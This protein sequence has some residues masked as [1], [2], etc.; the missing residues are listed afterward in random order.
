MIYIY[1]MQNYYEIIGVSVNSDETTIK[2]AYL[3]KIKFY[4]PDVYEG[5]KL[6]AEQMTAK[7]NEAYNTLKDEELRQAYDNSLKIKQLKI[8]NE[9][10]FLK[11]V[12]SKIK[13]G[14]NNIIKSIKKFIKW[15][16]DG[17]KNVFNKNINTLIQEQ[18]ERKR[19]NIIILIQSL[20]IILLLILIVLT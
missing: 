4:H 7:L 5:D 10:N 14:I 8:E 1:Y 15:I 13:N 19:L 3:Q 20:L 16:S 6:F 2:N 12:Y 17:I 9:K 11:L 18:K